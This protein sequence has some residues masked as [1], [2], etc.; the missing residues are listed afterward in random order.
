MLIVYN[1]SVKFLHLYL[2]LKAQNCVGIVDDF[3]FKM[4]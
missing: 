3:L 4:R 1:I 2:V